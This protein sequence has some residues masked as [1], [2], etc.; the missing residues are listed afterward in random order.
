MINN[1]G[2]FIFNI[3]NQLFIKSELTIMKVLIFIPQ[4]YSIKNTIINGFSSQGYEVRSID[5]YNYFP[6]WK[7]RIKGKTSALNY[8]IK[9]LWDN[10]FIHEVNKKHLARL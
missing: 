7:L 6:N 9:Y 10:Y 8:K 1:N 4:S 3:S 2:I 5:L